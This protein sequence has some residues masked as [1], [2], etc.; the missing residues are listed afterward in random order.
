MRI[1]EIH[2]LAI[3]RGD[4]FAVGVRVQALD[5]RVPELPPATRD[6]PSR[7]HESSPSTQVGN[8]S[9]VSSRRAAFSASGRVPRGPTRTRQLAGSPSVGDRYTG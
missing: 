5:E 3:D 7:C 9:V 4:D 8:F 1:G 6:E 2:L